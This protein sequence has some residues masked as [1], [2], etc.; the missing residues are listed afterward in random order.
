MLAL[1]IF[2]IAALAALRGRADADHVNGAVRRIV[3]GIAQKILRR[4]FPV[5]RHIPL[6]DAA[7]HLRATLSSIPAVQ[8]H[9]QVQFHLAEIL[10]ERR[11][12]LV[13]RGP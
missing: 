13:P 8:Q 9:V 4:E 2:V 10:E 6:L 1:V 3:I 12:F 7:Q 11:R 5:T